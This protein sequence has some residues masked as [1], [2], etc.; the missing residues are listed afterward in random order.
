M[1]TK[2]MADSGTVTVVFT[3]EFKCGNGGGM[4]KTYPSESL[5]PKQ[6]DDICPSCLKGQLFLDRE[7]TKRCY[8]TIISALN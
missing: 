1:E 3:C 6:Y 4:D 7:A 2:C 5:V 8:G